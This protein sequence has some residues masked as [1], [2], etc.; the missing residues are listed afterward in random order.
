MGALAK[1]L[2]ARQAPRAKKVADPPGG[3]SFGTSWLGGPQHTDPFGARRAPSPW[4]LIEKYVGLIYA[5]VARARDA[6][7]RAVGKG[8]IGCLESRG[9]AQERRQ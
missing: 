7:A 9:K 5:C 3:F 2:L 4:Q 1:R 6:V 8:R